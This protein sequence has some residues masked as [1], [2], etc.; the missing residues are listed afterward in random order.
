LLN[1]VKMVISVNV[2]CVFQGSGRYKRA[3]A[4]SAGEPAGKIMLDSHSIRKLKP[5]KISY[6]LSNT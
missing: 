1:G 6:V 2:L 4:G 5:N 3:A